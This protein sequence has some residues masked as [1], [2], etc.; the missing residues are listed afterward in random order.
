MFLIVLTTFPNYSLQAIFK[1]TKLIRLSRNSLKLKARSCVPPWTSQTI[2]IENPLFF[3]WIPTCKKALRST[4]CFLRYWQPK[5]HPT[6]SGEDST[7]TT[8]VLEKTLNLMQMP[9]TF[10]IDK[11]QHH[12]SHQINYE[13]YLYLSTSAE[14]PKPPLLGN[15]KIRKIQWVI[16][17]K[18]C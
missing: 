13:F 17:E 3:S 14:P 1:S 4:C 6:W 5:N 8:E 2:P 16:F 18:N 9:E 7:K 11:F 15:I 12:W 10:T